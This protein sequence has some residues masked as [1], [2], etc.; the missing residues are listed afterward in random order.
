MSL[1]KDSKEFQKVLKDFID[2]NED[3]GICIWKHRPSYYFKD[4]GKYKS[5]NTRYAHTIINHISK[6]TGYIT[7]SIFNNNCEL[8]TLIYI[9]MTGE[10]PENTIDHKDTNKTNNTWHNLREATQQQNS[11]NKS[12]RSDNLLKVKGVTKN[13]NGYMARLNINKKCKYLGTFNTID[14]AKLVYDTEAKKEHLTFF[15]G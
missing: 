9:L 10:F 7:T 11:V 3:T 13:G 14:E 15:R 5:W 4:I 6:S 12:V 1:M 8:H 2:Y